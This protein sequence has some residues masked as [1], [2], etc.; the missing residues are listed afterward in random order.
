M[1]ASFVNIFILR[2][3]RCRAIRTTSLVEIFVNLIGRNGRLFSVAETDGATIGQD[4]DGGVAY[5]MATYF[6]RMRPTRALGKGTNG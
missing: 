4:D 5:I 3:K 2:P 6:Y 1:R